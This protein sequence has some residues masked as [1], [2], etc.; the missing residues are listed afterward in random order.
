VG[1]SVASVALGVYL[2]RVVFSGNGAKLLQMLGSE[3]AFLKWAIALSALLAFKNT[4][5]G[6][7]IGG[8]L[9]S[10]TLLAMAIKTAQTGQLQTGAAE[11]NKF[12]K[13]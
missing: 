8:P 12:F 3:S 9:I 1:N 13:N 2:L 6:A 11:I 5:A 7:E 4:R 10:I